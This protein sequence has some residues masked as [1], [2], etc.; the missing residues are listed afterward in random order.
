M[1]TNKIYWKHHNPPLIF[2]DAKT[3]EKNEVHKSLCCD[4][5]TVNQIWLIGGMSAVISDKAQCNLCIL[6]KDGNRNQFDITDTPEDFSEAE[7][8][9]NSLTITN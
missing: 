7:N 4:N 8:W 3:G 1:P 6:M 9:L 2:I 5:D